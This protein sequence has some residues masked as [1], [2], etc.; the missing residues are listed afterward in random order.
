MTE[1]GRYRIQSVAEMTGVSAATL[2]AWER[3]Y[4][5]PAPQR[6][7][8]AYRL[9]TDRDVELIRRVRELCA[10]GVAPAQ[11]VQM[12]RSARGGFEETARLEIDTAE[13]T[14]QRILAA[15][16]RFGADLIEARGQVIAS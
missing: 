3:R 6:T 7:A 2:R 9:Y 1:L 15:G 16:E 14:V 4:G 13:L 11:A 10:N 8:S 5:I 12:I